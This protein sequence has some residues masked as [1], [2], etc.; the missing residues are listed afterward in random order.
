[1]GT[2]VDGIPVPGRTDAAD[3]PAQLLAM[4]EAIDLRIDGVDGQADSDVASLSARITALEGVVASLQTSTGKTQVDLDALELKYAN[5]VSWTKIGTSRIEVRSIV[6]TT[7]SRG[8]FTIIFAK[9]FKK[10]PLVVLTSGSGYGMATANGSNWPP[11]TAAPGPYTHDNSYGGWKYTV[12][13]AG[14]SCGGMKASTMVRM[15]YIAVGE[16]VYTDRASNLGGPGW[17]IVTPTFP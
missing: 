3:A 16:S 8:F 6:K 9:P 1:M 15:N 2:D 5:L 12:S 14:L 4:A 17:D 13:A 7:D 10:I 11:T